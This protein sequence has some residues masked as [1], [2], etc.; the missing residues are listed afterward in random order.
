MSGLVKIKDIEIFKDSTYNSFPN[1]LTLKD[2]TVFVGFR[3]APDWQR[4]GMETHL[5]P[6]SKAVFVT[7]KDNGCTWDNNTNIIYDDY[8][9]GVQD[10]CLNLL[11]DGTIFATF[12][13]WKAFHKNDVEALPT[14]IKLKDTWIGRLDKV[15]SIRTV[16]NGKTWDEPIPIQCLD[17]QRVALRGNGVELDN[18]EI[19][20]PVYGVSTAEEA[21]KVTIIKTKDRGLTWTNI[22]RISFSDKYNLEEPLIFKTKGGKLVAFIRTSRYK[23]KKTYQGDKNKASPLV[24]CESYDDGRTWSEPVERNMYSPSPFHALQ[25][26]S[27]NV[28]VT[29]GYRYEPFGIRAFIL[30]GECTNFDDVK[31]YVLR[32]DGL[33]GDIG[34]TNSTQL[35]NGDI[36][37]TYYYYEEDGIRYI[38]GT[39]CKEE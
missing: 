21:G 37:I 9:Y 1:A 23:D 27:G 4:F 3:N 32:D 22:S 10:P 14:D 33:G 6:G 5:D 38:A 16:D 36:L 30:N 39:I 12:Y 17:D 15:Y 7:S 8:V 29:Y 35:N 11:K 28:L 20:V 18:G 19:I 2:G 31:E 24:T 25:L 13:M 34:Y 26:S